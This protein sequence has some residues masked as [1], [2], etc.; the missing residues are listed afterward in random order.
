[1]APIARQTQPLY[2]ERLFL[3][4]RGRH[5]L[6]HHW[7]PIATIRPAHRVQRATQNKHL[8]ERLAKLQLF[9]AHFLLNELFD[10]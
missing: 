1:M 9:V 2:T 5:S 8:A 3:I 4:A 7:E 6:H 10:V